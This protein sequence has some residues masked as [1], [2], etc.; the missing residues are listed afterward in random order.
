M[1]G[2]RGKVLDAGDSPPRCGRPRRDRPR[3][4][5]PPG[6][7][8]AG[9]AAAGAAAG[10]ASPSATYGVDG[11]EALREVWTLQLTSSSSRASRS[12]ARSSAFRPVVGSLRAARA[13]LSFATVNDGLSTSS[14]VNGA[15]GASAPAA[16]VAARTSALS[17]RSRVS[18][19]EYALSGPRVNG[20][21]GGHGPHEASPFNRRMYARAHSIVASR[22][23]PA[24]YSGSWCRK[25]SRLMWPKGPSAGHNISPRNL[26]LV[27][28][29]SVAS[30]R[31]S[32]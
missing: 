4:R 28:K 23:T 3:R 22:A 10:A 7:R 2:G 13:A 5:R 24:S 18:L 1:G 11:V 16:A 17:S 26:M 14:L 29:A 9:A 15:A 30:A 25:P 20:A 8:R 12:R 19:R 32:P 31:A 6:R 21:T 27:E